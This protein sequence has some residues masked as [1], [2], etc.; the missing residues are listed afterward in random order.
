MIQPVW[1]MHGKDCLAACIATITGHKITDL[2][3]VIK[4]AFARATRDPMQSIGLWIDDVNTYMEFASGIREYWSLRGPVGQPPLGLGIAIVQPP[5]LEDVNPHAVVTWTPPGISRLSYIAHD[6]GFA[7]YEFDPTC[8][9]FIEVAV[10]DSLQ[11]KGF[12][13]SYNKAREAVSDPPF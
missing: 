10:S 5:D 12:T 13:D 1:S 8:F 6:P 3:L 2:D 11:S 4:D 7:P 9:Y